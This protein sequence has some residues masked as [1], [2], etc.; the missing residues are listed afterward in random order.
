MQK[1]RLSDKDL[2][3]IKLLF[4]RHFG[5]NDHL[6]LFGSRADMTKR[7]GDIDLYVETHEADKHIA[8]DKERYF[9][10]ALQKNLDE[11]KIDIITNILPRK[12]S[13]PIYNEAKQTGVMLV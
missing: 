2:E 8:W 9:W 7:G 11:Q 13:L 12:F 1:V 3:Q 4:R 10:V 6:W 5:E